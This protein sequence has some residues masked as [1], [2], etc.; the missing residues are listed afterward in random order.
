MFTNYQVY[1]Y[2]NSLIITLICCATSCIQHALLLDNAE[3]GSVQASFVAFLCMENKSDARVSQGVTVTTLKRY[4]VTLER[5]NSL[6]NDFILLVAPALNVFD[7]YCLILQAMSST[8]LKL[9][10]ERNFGGT[11]KEFSEECND[12]TRYLPKGASSIVVFKDSDAW[13][14]FT[15]LSFRGATANLESDRK[16]KSL[17][18]MG[19]TGPVKSFRKAP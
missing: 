15:E 16:Y 3:H 10:E 6:L 8:I 4:F 9:F 1:G 2:C 7:I 13:Q 18:E 12:V 17:E 5:L 19:L 14:V 11:S